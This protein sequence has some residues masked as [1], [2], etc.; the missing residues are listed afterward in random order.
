MR[1]A[2]LSL[3]HGLVDPDTGNPP[4]LEPYEGAMERRTFL[5]LRVSPARAWRRRCTAR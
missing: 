1:L 2:E 5:P 4:H 3:E